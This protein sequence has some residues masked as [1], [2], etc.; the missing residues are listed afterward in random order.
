MNKKKNTLIDTKPNI[1]M[2]GSDLT[3]LGGVS[4]V[5]REYLKAGLDKKV[6]LV[7]V[8]SH[9]DGSKF[10]K[11]L[12]LI[13]AIKTFLFLPWEKKS[14]VHMH[15]SHGASFFRKLL[16]MIIAKIKRQKVIMHLHGSDYEEFMHQSKLHTLLTKWVFDQSDHII[17]LSKRWENLL[18]NFTS[19]QNI[20]TLYNPATQLSDTH[21]G[22][23]NL[24]VLFLGRLGRRKGVYDLLDVITRDKH[25]YEERQVSFILAGD[26]ETD[27]VLKRVKENTLEKIVDVPG[28]VSGAE[29][30]AYL[31]NAHIFI[32]PSYNEQMP[33]SILEAMAHG[34][35]ILATDIAGIPEM[36][37]QGENGYLFSPGDLDA[38]EKYLKI[39]CEDEQLREK[40]G[41]KSKQIIND[42]F[43]GHL[44][45]D[46]LVEIY[47]D[48]LN[49]S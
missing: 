18:K 16:L 8:P 28:W 5:V 3:V 47:G 6:N 14:I 1:I 40:M 12:K 17:V 35:P 25:Y 26:G 29:K 11:L 32:L 30:D 22:Q 34:Y 43:D 24:K 33:M 41:L 21:H 46:K 38:F 7:L 39:L 19:N 42:K 44:I 2:M 36:V 9:I 13:Q 48:V 23:G 37:E 4:E 27:E 20:T 49:A 31:K 15:L 45:T 10:Q